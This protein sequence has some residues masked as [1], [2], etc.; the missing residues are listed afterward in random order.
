ML[1]NPRLASYP[2]LILIL[3]KYPRQDDLIRDLLL[4]D[5]R[6][7]LARG[8]LGQPVGHAEL[9]LPHAHSSLACRK[10]LERGK[11]TMMGRARHTGD[12]DGDVHDILVTRMGTCTTYW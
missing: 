7:E 8:R 1:D 4:D 6:A 3:D 5:A 10:K 2:I 12:S 9:G 11:R